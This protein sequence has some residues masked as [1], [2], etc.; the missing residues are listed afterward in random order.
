VII[1]CANDEELAELERFGAEKMAALCIVSEVKFAKSS[2]GQR[3]VTAQKSSH[4]KC[5]RC[6]NYWPS[7]GKNEKYP[8]LCERCEEVVR[9][10]MSS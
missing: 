10:V 8:D 3:V 2:G 6:W 9:G 5:Q 1:E 7:V 4:Q